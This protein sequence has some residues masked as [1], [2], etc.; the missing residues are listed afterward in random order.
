MTLLLH[1]LSL[2]VSLSAVCNDCT[3][4]ELEA[5]I[6]AMEREEKRNDEEELR[7]GKD[8]DGDGDIGEAG[9]DNE[10]RLLARAAELAKRKLQAEQEKD[11][12]VK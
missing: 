9:H 2:S 10:E 4:Q 6:A 8:L 11:E 1:P 12:R 7:V 3:T 5:E